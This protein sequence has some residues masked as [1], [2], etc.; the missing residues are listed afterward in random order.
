[1]VSL[2]VSLPH[3]AGG[4]TDHNPRNPADLSVFGKV[5]VVLPCSFKLVPELFEFLEDKPDNS[6]LVDLVGEA[7]KVKDRAYTGEHDSSPAP[8]QAGET[9][10]TSCETLA[11][12]D[13]AQ[14]RFQQVQVV[15]V[16]LL[17]ASGPW[18]ELLVI[19][20]CSP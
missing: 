13:S 18:T 1:M 14:K 4:F 10:L 12:A 8:P 3:G 15:V 20:A 6:P 16:I 7:T 17:R 2:S 11:I 19:P 5:D 9:R